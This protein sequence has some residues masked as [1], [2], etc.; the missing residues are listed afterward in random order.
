M[1]I[2]I[3][4]EILSCRVYPGDPAPKSEKL[5]DMEKG[6]LYNLTAFSMC[7]HNGTH[8]DAP[9][10]FIKDGRTV[11]MLPPDTFVGRCTVA[12]CSGDV[13]GADAEKILS[14]A[15]ACNAGERILIKGDAVV[16]PPAARVFA[17]AGIKLLGV[18]SRSVGPVDAPMEVHI[19]LLS[20]GVALRE[21]LVLGTVPPGQYTLFCAPLNIAG[22]EGSPCR[23]FLVK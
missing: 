11:D 13:T 17:R 10:H 21:G 1:I 16:T 20:A 6:D 23:A 14:A 12:A 7:C 3:T 4:Q 5:M 18:E 9:A 8:I 22:A 2:D 15:T 19:I